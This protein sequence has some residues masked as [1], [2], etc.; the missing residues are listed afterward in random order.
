MRFHPLEKLIN[1]HDGYQRQFK[2]DNLQVLLI[3]E[4][5]EL[6]LCESH[7]PHRDHPLRLGAIHGGTIQCVLH[8][9]RFSLVDG[10]VLQASEEPCRALRIFEVVY[11]GADV[12]LMIDG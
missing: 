4:M 11:S 9:Y 8:R 5:G 1:L 3:Q 6:F 7:C 12:G 10:S 2:I